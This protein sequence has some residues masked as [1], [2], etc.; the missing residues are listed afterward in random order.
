MAFGLNHKGFWAKSN[1]PNASW[2]ILWIRILDHL[3]NQV[4]EMEPE[5]KIVPDFLFAKLNESNHLSGPLS[6]CQALR[7]LRECIANV[8][9][10]HFSQ[11]QVQAYTLHSCKSTLL[12]WSAQLTL[13]PDLRACQGHHVFAHSVQL[14][15]RDDVYPSLQL[16]SHVS[17]A[18]QQGWVPQTPQERGSQPPLHEPKFNTPPINMVSHPSFTR[19]RWL[20][21]P[22]HVESSSEQHTAA[23]ASSNPH[24]QGTLASIP[25]EKDES[26]ILSKHAVRFIVH[27]TT[28][29]VAIVDASTPL[30]YRC[31]CGAL[32]SKTNTLVDHIPENTRMCRRAACVST[33]QHY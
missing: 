12:S 23:P 11:Q 26:I 6:Y 28:A 13:P 22:M 7:I 19:F 18:L 10:A 14:Y 9:F 16:Q 30:G 32:C 20:A 4:C 3:W 25:T 31:K 8:P 27:K 15:S 1:N 17:N 29:H 5:T 24:D 33:F 21:E 2:L